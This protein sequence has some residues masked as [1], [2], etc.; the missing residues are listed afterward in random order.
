MIVNIL[1]SYCISSQ[2]SKFSLVLCDNLDGSKIRWR[3]EITLKRDICI[4]TADLLHCTS[5]LPWWKLSG[6]ESPYH[7]GNSGLSP[8]SGDLWR[9]NLSCSTILA[10]RI[11]LKK[12]E[13]AR[14]ATV[15]GGGRVGPDW[16]TVTHTYNPDRYKTINAHKMLESKHLN[17]AFRVCICFYDLK[18]IIKYIARYLEV[19]IQLCFCSLL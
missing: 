14:Q 19:K 9:K 16:A 3:R 6:K 10:W 17:A 15:H 11:H 8:V 12:P 7:N 4:H 13:E 18:W 1:P 5:R 2:Y